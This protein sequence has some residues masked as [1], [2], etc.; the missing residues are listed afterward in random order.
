MRWKKLGRI[1]DP[2]TYTL[3]N[4]C[5]EYTQSPQVLVFDDFVRIYFSTREK[6]KNA[7]YLSYVSFVDINKDFKEIIN[8]S[9]DK[10][11]E[12]GDL[13]CFDE[14]GIV[15]MNVVR[16]KDRIF[17]YTTGWNRR[18][19]VS[20]D[21]SIGFA[22]SYDNGL[23]F[24]KM[25]KGPIL[26]PSLHEPFLVGDAFV[27]IYGET[28]HMWYIYGI[29]W[30]KFSKDEAA[31]RIYK[32]GHATSTDGISWHKEGGQIIT[33]R[34]IPDECQAHPTVIYYDHKYHMLFCYRYATDF[35]KNRDRGYRIGY[36][37]SEDLKNWTRDDDNVGIDL[38]EDG[39]D[40]D[41]LCYPHIFQCDGKIYLLYNG[42]EFGRYGFGLA[43]LED[44]IN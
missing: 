23:T 21:A 39:W 10:V 34:L 13:G 40:S 18:L 8:I 12:F 37:Y 17:A 28:Y 19:S 27:A 20:V 29:K 32:I 4:H 11:I 2:T 6:D 30:V 7:K 35:R 1:F 24:K 9:R 26:S 16:D 38:S 15:P 25:G 33:D 31:E 22:I 36:A 5:L 14:H 44:A 3:S 41:M 42:N 43:V